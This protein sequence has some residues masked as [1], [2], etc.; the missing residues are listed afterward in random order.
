[1][2]QRDW[3]E[4]DYYFILG[5]SKDATKEDIKKAYRKLAQ[6]FHPDAN[7]DDAAAEARFKEISEAHG[8]LSNTEK[9]REYDQIRTFAGGG[10][11]YGFRPGGGRVRVNVGDLGDLGDLFGD[12][13]GGVF[14]DLLGGFGFRGGPRTM[15]GQDIETE[16]HLDFEDSINGVTV[17]LPEG[18]KAKI[19]TGVG[20]GARI[21]L[22]GRGE[23]GM[24]GGPPGDL[25]VRVR[26]KPHPMF[27][28]AATGDLTVKVP[29]TI[30]EAALGT[31]VEVPTL[32]G[33]VTVKIPSGTQHGKKLRVKGR[34]GPAPKGGHRDLIVTVEVAVPAKLN[35]KEK[36]VLEEFADL[37]SESPRA[38]LEAYLK[39]IADERRVS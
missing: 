33:S 15:R 28:R 3:M 29:V 30:A 26:V 2:A 34:G 39:K 23:P 8:V 38:D 21:K 17:T 35:R 5:V 20:D 16:V 36:E 13:G 37:H 32:D 22:A 6:K 11:G 19:P 24:N 1:M 12:Q 18:T 27:G 7:K 25:Y 14:E 9:R 4:K 10:G 31:K